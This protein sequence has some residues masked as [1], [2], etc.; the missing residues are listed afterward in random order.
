MLKKCPTCRQK[1]RPPSRG[2]PSQY[3]S[4]ACRQKAYRKRQQSVPAPLRALKRDIATIRNRDDV[5][6]Q[7]IAALE[8][9]GYVVTLAP[10]REARVLRRAEGAAS[11]IIKRVSKPK[12]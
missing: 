4:S 7:A 10:D 8:G 6:K 5:R 11:E 3:C 2:R 12:P 1:Y 9:L